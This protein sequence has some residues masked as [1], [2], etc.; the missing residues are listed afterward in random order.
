MAKRVIPIQWVDPVTGKLTMNAVR[1]LDDLDN[2]GTNSIG[3][4]L[5]GVNTVTATTA[6]IIAGTVAID[7]TITG[8]GSL[9][10]ELDATSANVASA[11]SSASAGA[12]A[13]SV[14]PTYAFG[15]SGAGTVTTNTVTVTASGGTAPYTYAW[16]RKSGV[17]SVAA[18]DATS[19]ATTFSEVLTAGQYRTN[20]WTCTVTDSAGSPATTT[21]DVAVTLD[22]L[23]V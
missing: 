18:T 20:V 16:T 7:P 19:A 8:R 11:A 15:Q 1:Y 3:T 2:G 23:G 4:L 21:V 6:G 5:A 22:C 9:A 12:L 10:E 13:A 14:S 17:G